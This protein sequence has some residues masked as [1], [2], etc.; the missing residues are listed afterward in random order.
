MVGII[1]DCEHALE[2]S[3]RLLTGVENAETSIASAKANLQALIEEV[4]GEITE[5]HQLE[6]QGKAQGSPA[7]WS[8]LEDLLSTA[9]AAVDQARSNGQ[10]D[11]LGQYT[12]LTAIDTKLDEQ[13]DTVRETNSTRERQLSLYRQ[14]MASAESSLSLIHI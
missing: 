9:R 4:E 3:D 8:A 13:L 1:R 2:V 14:Q 12:A 5:A 7:D 6:Q 10:A 11:P